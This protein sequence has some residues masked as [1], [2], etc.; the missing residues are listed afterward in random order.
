M[1]VSG[2]A[3]KLFNIVFLITSVTSYITPDLYKLNLSGVLKLDNC[4]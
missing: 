2:F 4:I 1:D 3:T